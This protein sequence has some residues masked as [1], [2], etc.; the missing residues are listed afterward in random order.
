[1]SSMIF[2]SHD[3]SEWYVPNN[4]FWSVLYRG[5]EF[6]RGMALSDAESSW[7]QGLEAKLDYQKNPESPIQTYSPDVKIDDLFANGD[8]IAFWANVFHEVCL[9]ERRRACD[10]ED[11]RAVF[12]STELIW[13][14]YGL[15]RFLRHEAGIR[16]TSSSW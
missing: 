10:P 8:E 5:V 7:V 12:R 16:G 3:E 9:S 15:A 13:A 1:M 2:G 11:E 6:A 14:M 4:V